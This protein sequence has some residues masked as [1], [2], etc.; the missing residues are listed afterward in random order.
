MESY[1]LSWKKICMKILYKISNIVI[2]SCF[3]IKTQD[4]QRVEKICHQAV[5]K[6]S[7]IVFVIM[8]ESMSM[9]L[10]SLKS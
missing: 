9:L 2:S 7:Y 3:K 6:L 10:Y 5:A 8:I 1:I 4:F